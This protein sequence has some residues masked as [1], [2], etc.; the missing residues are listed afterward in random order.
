MRFRSGLRARRLAAI[1]CAFLLAAVTAAQSV[2]VADPN[3]AELYRNDLDTLA[4]FV[5]ANHP[6]AVDAKNPEFNRTLADSYEE[7]IRAGGTVT[8]Y[9]SYAVALARFGNRFQDHQLRIDATRPLGEI[10]HAGLYPVYRHGGFVIAGADARYGPLSA[11]LLGAEVLGCDSSDVNKLFTERVL[12]WQGRRDVESDWYAAA[13]LLF[14]DF[15]PPTPPAPVNCRFAVADRKVEIPLIWSAAP[16]DVVRQKQIA[17]AELASRP[18]DV[19]ILDSGRAIWVDIPTFGAEEEDHAALMRAVRDSL[20]AA[21]KARPKWRLLVLDLRGNH[22]GQSRWGDEITQLLFGKKWVRQADA[23]LNDGVYSEWRVSPFN[24]RALWGMLTEIER[25][26][27]A[28]SADA[29]RMRL[30]VDSMFVALERGDS[31]YGQRQRR[32]GVK[33]PPA[34]KLPGRIVVL[35]SA[36]CYDAC[37]GFLDRVKLHPAAL[38]V[39]QITGAETSYSAPWGMQLPNGLASISIPLS[40]QRNRRRAHNEPHDPDVAYLGNIADGEAVRGWVLRSYS[41]W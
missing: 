4:A 31:L 32:R 29:R 21:L 37:L 41:S 24:I 35:T 13:P 8:D 25:R 22:A 5:A 9:A 36:G 14:A 34:P 16:S 2:L 26:H 17:L 3:W 15:G 18:P 1:A 11:A 6:G 33:R 39:G 27:G 23:W 40:V 20:A 7:A 38:Q 19:E 28:E 30:V 12:S 10:R